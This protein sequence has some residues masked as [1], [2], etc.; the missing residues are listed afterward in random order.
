M[1]L[2]EMER[3]LPLEDVKM[4][5]SRTIGWVDAV[6]RLWSR[7]RRVALWAI[8]CLLTSTLFVLRN[9]KYDATVSLIPPHSG[10]GGLSGLLPAI[11]KVSGL[12]CGGGSGLAGMAGDMIGIKSSGALFT[13]VLQSHT[14][15]DAVVDKFDL[16]PR[17]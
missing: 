11:S 14:H 17:V 12:S 5:S 1:Q 10:S 7:K 9:C 15:A 13:K 6:N 2:S 4:N 8:V 16:Q 3:E